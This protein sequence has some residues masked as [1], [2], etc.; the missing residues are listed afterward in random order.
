MN[1]LT[2]SDRKKLK[3]Q[4]HDLKPV[5]QVGKFGITPALIAAVD[6]ALLDHEL[7]KVKF[8]DFKDEK[9]EL[10]EKISQETGSE[11]ISV[12][13]NVLTLYKENEEEV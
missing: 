1:T 7:I 6:K 12:I 2:L 10:S 8:M 9:K 3:S 13:G 5:I 4:A 11:I